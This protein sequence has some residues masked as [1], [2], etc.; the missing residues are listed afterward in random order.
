M[1]KFGG[2]WTKQKIHIV[3]L[4]AKAY[5]TIMKDKRYWSLLY[6]DGFAGTG[7]INTENDDFEITEGAAKKIL[8][9]DK[10]RP[11]DMY[12]FVELDCAK[13]EKLEKMVST[14]Y[15]ADKKKV[16]FQAADCN[17]KLLDLAKFLNSGKGKN[18]KVLAFI[19]PCGMELKWKS[20]EALK[21]LG[22]DLWILVPTGVGANRLLKKDGNIS[23]AWILRLEQFLGIDKEEIMKTFYQQYQT[24]TLFGTEDI[25]EKERN[26][27][28]KIHNLY[29][30]RLKTIFKFV[31]DSFVMR[32][33][34]NSI[35]FHFFMAT[36][37]STALKIA[38]D[39]LKPKYRM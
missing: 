4:Y 20:L 21:D 19:D 36:N 2:T 26:S 17:D 14:L 5:L 35:M 6:F 23:D 9:I 18:Y 29:K 28:E 31:S 24:Q 38:N 3:E 37:N 1:N 8:N 33:S 34:M 27:I 7:E 39:I 30:T 22:I 15:P 11:F 10:P 16:F 32:N 25:L 12:Y 13:K